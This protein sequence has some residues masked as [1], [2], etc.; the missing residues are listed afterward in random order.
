MAPPHGG[1]TKDDPYFALALSLN[2][3]IWSDEEAFKQQS[4][5]KVFNT[6]KL[7]ELIELKKESMQEDSASED[8]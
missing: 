1:E 2:C 4:R 3:P 5:I 7:S 8:K 6:K